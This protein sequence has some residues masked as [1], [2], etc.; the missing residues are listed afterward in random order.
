ME[1]EGPRQVEPTRDLRERLLAR[2]LQ[3]VAVVGVVAYL[4]SAYLSIKEGLW[5]VL[6][7]DTAA[8]L[9]VV[10][11][12]VF[13][14]LP[15]RLR[16]LSLVFIAYSLGVV[17][18]IFTGPFGAGHL[19]IFAFVFLASLF[20]GVREI[21]LA[22]ALAVLTHLGFTA[23]SALHLVR[24]PQGPESVI[25]ISANFILISL[26]LSY[27]ANY[28]IRGY[29]STASRE[30]GLRE[31]LE[32]LVKEIEH[33]VKN[34]LQVIASLV[35]LRGGPG[36]DPVRALEDIKET[37]SAISVVH[38]LLYRRSAFYLVELSELLCSLT[39]RFRNLDR[40]INFSMEWKGAKVEIDGDRAISMGLLINEIIMN[41][42]KHAFPRKEEGSVYVHVD[43]D[44]ATRTMLLSI[45]DDGNGMTGDESAAERNGMKIIRA[46]ARQLEARMELTRVPS[47]SY[48]FRMKI[49]QPETDLVG[50]WK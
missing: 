8:F 48:L 9:Y 12:A 5:H 36:E 38:Q 16:I 45:G 18:I 39:D 19:F 50:S 29:S 10:C 46:L 24:W 33:R 43:Y 32:M 27:S 4:P 41:S 17:L 25:V 47:V 7:I 37:I 35:G 3:I 34:N 31:A 20:G 22:N 21:I 6:A 44:S 2:L 23:A 42:V 14:R 28:L 1:R 26:V 15:F 49:E 11:L 13:K 40:R 30:K